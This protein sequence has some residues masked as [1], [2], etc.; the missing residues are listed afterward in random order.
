M[1]KKIK[2]LFSNL[3]YKKVKQFI[4]GASLDIGAQKQRDMFDVCADIKP[5]G[6][7]MQYQDIMNMTYED[8]K[9]DTVCALEIL[10]HVVNPI[11]ALSELKRVA[12][13]RIIISVPF[14]PVFSLLRLSW[15]K[16]HL[17]ALTEKFI[18]YHI[19]KEPIYKKIIYLRWLFLVYDL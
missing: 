17:I 6:K 1:I 11:K 16:E 13:K 12:K 19:G 14:E 2:E 7:V 3:R 9:F 15:E 4:I 8:N 10:E 5:D 18:T